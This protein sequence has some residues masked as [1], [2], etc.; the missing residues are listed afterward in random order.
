MGAA[1]DPSRSAGTADARA[2]VEGEVA[3]VVHSDDRTTFRVLRLKLDDGQSTTVAGLGPAAATGERVRA[4]GRWEKTKYGKQLRAEVI[5]PADAVSDQGLARSIDGIAPGIGIGRARRIVAELGGAASAIRALDSASLPAFT[6]LPERSRVD[7]EQAWR[8]HRV[9][10]EVEARLASLDLTPGLRARLRARYGAD[11]PRM[12]VEEPYRIAEEVEGV[13]FLTADDVARKAGLPTDSPA[14]I[15]AALLHALRRD[16]E[17]GGHT[18]GS[19]GEL[20]ATLM[21]IFRERPAPAS[22]AADAA[23]ATVAAVTR[24]LER[25]AVEVDESGGPTRGRV[26]LPALAEAER[27]VSAGIERVVASVADAPR[28][29]GVEAALAAAGIPLSEEQSAA[30]HSVAEAGIAVVTGGPGTGKSHLTKAIVVLAGH[31]GLSVAL[32]APTARAARRLAEA[33]GRGDACTIHRLL[34]AGA[35]GFARCAENPLSVDVVLVDETSMVD[36][37]LMAALLRALPL[38]CRLV[39]VG[40]AD[41]LPPVGPGAPFR[42]VIASGAVSVARLTEIHRQARGSAIVVG[43][44]AVLAGKT[45]AAS[46]HGDRSDG[47]LHVVA[48]GSAEDAADAVLEVVRGMR[49]ELGVDPFEAMVL[50]PMRKGACGVTALNARLQEMLNPAREGVAELAFGR[51]D[52]ARLFRVGDKVRQTKNDY[53]RGVVN[54][55]L[56]RVAEVYG[57]RSEQRVRHDY[58]LRV[59]LDDGGPD[60]EAREVDYGGA[61]LRHLVLAYCGTI[62]S[63][64]GGQFPAVVMVMHDCHFVMLSRTI[65]YTGMTRAQHAC[66]VVGSRRAIE[67]AARNARVEERRTALPGLL[68]AITTRTTRTRTAAM[69]TS[70]SSQVEQVEQ[71]KQVEQVE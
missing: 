55:D 8:E 70:A 10:R 65:L 25:R 40:D 37:S 24:C 45:P 23:G 59:R 7:L 49:D 34:E 52:W 62:H 22:F 36:T 11:A 12:V 64:Q 31:A 43:A 35:K 63:S 38:R 32:C 6:W 68:L 17:E 71:V 16:A 50:A 9:E 44:H 42:D 29:E 4:V 53:A 14:R 46:P 66:V 20:Q 15:D 19:V 56:G 67:V 61:D 69:V 58:L 41:Q 1:S 54:G 21:R 13:G 33:T 27:A 30:V 39:L 60:G 3:H 47:C 26:A 2:T 18:C 48:R 57:A 28:I 5:S 51:D